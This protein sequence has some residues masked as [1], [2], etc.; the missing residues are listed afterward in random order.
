MSEFLDTDAVTP[1]IMTV[2]R[3][4][5]GIAAAPPGI[6]NGGFL[7]QMLLASQAEGEITA[8][9]AF[10]GPGVVTHWHSHP[11]GQLLFVL[12]GVGFAQRE[13]SDIVEIRAGDS[14]WFAPDERHRHGAS[15]SCPFSYLSVQAVKDGTTVHWLEGE[16]AKGAWS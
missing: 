3:A 1:P 12:E 14:V 4:G 8:M 9:R 16:E 15:P 5:S 11:R 13:G 2:K 6:S 7:I 10:V